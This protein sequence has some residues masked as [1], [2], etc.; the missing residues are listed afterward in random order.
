MLQYNQPPISLH[1]IILATSLRN[2]FQQWCGQMGIVNNGY[3]F[4]IKIY[5][6][7]LS[8][9]SINKQE[10]R[11][12]DWKGN[13]CRTTIDLPLGFFS[14][15]TQQVLL[16]EL[17]L[18]TIPEHMCSPLVFSEVRVT[19]SLVLCVCFVDRCLSFCNL[20]FGRCVVCPSSI[21]GL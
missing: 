18:P 5:Q 1:P 17:E 11:M 6:H 20:S 16:V 3:K 7:Q 10:A 9:Q 19:R 12:D 2:M 14:R 15:S 8:I 13:A 21:Y 4:I